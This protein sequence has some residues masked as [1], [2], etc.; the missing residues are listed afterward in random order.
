MEVMN[1]S[2]AAIGRH[3]HPYNRHSASFADPLIQENP[4]VSTTTDILPA[5]H[6]IGGEWSPASSGK[7]SGSIDPAT[8]EIHAELAAGDASDVDRAVQ[9]ARESFDTGIWRSM[10]PSKR[11]RILWK[12]ADLIDQNRA[13]IAHAET[14]DTGKTAFDSGKIEVPLVAIEEIGRAHV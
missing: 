4:P 10:P 11:S 2:R 9:A 8:E 5:A 6:F 14:M 13:A 7:T 12:M 1:P 3:A